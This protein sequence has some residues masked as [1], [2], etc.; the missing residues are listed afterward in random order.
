MIGLDNFTLI[1]LIENLIQETILAL[2]PLLNLNLKVLLVYSNDYQPAI[3]F[4]KPRIHVKFNNFSYLLADIFKI[5][6]TEW[7]FYLKSE[8]LITI[9]NINFKELKFP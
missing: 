2:N 3:L 4:K 6:E 1:F 8:E 5:I 9:D 7:V